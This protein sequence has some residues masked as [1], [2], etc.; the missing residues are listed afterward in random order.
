MPDKSLTPRQQRRR[1]RRYFRLNARVKYLKFQGSDEVIPD[2]SRREWARKLE[3]CIVLRESLR[4]A[5]LGG[6]S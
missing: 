3:N 6:S 5:I 2:A 4:A 1:I